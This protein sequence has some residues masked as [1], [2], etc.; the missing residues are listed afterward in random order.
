MEEPP[1][2]VL[3]CGDV[4]GRL[5]TLFGR[6]RAIQ[7][8]S[9]RF[10]MLLCVG[11]FFSSTSDAEWAEYRSG[12]KK[13]K[14]GAVTPR[15]KCIGVLGAVLAGSPLTCVLKILLG[16]ASCPH[17]AVPFAEGSAQGA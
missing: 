6:V 9:G 11:D 5:E 1:L 16:C 2:R 10:D 12:A 7:S 4:E 8:K 14:E 17:K 13:G 15:S 3:A